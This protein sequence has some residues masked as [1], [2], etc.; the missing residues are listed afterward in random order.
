MRP[1]V[2]IEMNIYKKYMIENKYLGGPGETITALA[3]WDVEDELLYLD[4]P[5][6]VT[7]FPL[8]SLL[9]VFVSGKHKKYGKQS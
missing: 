3:D 2:R 4:F 1:W 7:Q 9:F 5:H 6:W 8:R